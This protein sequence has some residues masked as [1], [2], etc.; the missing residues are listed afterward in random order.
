MSRVRRRDTTPELALRRSLHRRG[1][2]YRIDVPPLPGLRTRADVLFRSARIA[3]YIDGCFWHSCP[4]HG[5]LP[6]NN[7]DWW[8]QKLS[9]TQARD[10]A[11]NTALQAAG[12]TV[13]RF[14]EH[15]NMEDAA[16]VVVLALDEHRR[17]NAPADH[18]DV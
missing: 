7:R 15:A 3:I 5:V 4:E 6:R 11:T 1:L 10:L 8:Q 2:R 17:Q 18:N 12:W 13:L 9:A 16:E 14:W